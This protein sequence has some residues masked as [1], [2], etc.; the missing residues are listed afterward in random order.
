M[1]GR[2]DRHLAFVSQNFKG[3]TP[4]IVIGVAIACFVTTIIGILVEN[5]SLAYEWLLGPPPFVLKEN[6]H[7]NS[8]A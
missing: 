3:A 5:A 2:S 6:L 1:A 8:L 7:N 4:P